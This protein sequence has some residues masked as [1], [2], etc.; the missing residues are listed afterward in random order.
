LAA[1]DLRKHPRARLAQNTPI[2][3]DF[4]HFAPTARNLR[5]EPTKSTA[6]ESRHEESG[7]EWL[8]P[9]WMGV[10]HKLIIETE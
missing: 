7:A 10:Y 3:D 5:A 2:L 8:L 9:Y 6:S 1:N 4:D